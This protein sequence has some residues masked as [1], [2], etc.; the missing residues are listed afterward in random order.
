VANARNAR[1]LKIFD[2]GPYAIGKAVREGGRFDEAVSYAERGKA[3]VL[4]DV[5]AS[6]K[7]FGNSSFGG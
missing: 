1:A 7:R 6:K 5:L 4:V 2:Q 3:R